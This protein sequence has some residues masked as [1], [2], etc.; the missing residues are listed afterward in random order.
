MDTT[1][2]KTDIKTDGVTGKASGG[3]TPDPNAPYYS[4]CIRTLKGLGLPLDGWFCAEVID[5]KEEDKNAPLGS[6][7]ACGCQS[8]R[9]IHIMK[10]SDT[11]QVLSVG[12][13]CAG[14]MENDELGARER[15]R[16][17]KNRAARR[18]T[19]IRKPWE[20]G[21]FDGLLFHKKTPV[22]LT[23][24]CA[25]DQAHQASAEDQAHQTRY[26]VL[27]DDRYIS[28]YKGQPILD[29]LTAKYAA[30]DVLDPVEMIK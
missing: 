13:I 7:E 22:V 17:M 26:T 25:E 11:L 14:E 21:M 20:S 8:V 23:A 5:V 12:C 15:E 18:R 30:F 24:V 4:R 1:D 3:F 28:E 2:I 6:C 19:F 9:Y 29:P 27:I 10:H 16:Q